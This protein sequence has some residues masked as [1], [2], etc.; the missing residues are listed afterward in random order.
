[1]RFGLPI[2][3]FRAN[4]VDLEEAYMRAGIGQVD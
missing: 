4:D 1:M 3:S 2:A